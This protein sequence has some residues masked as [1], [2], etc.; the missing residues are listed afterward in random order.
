M[1]GIFISKVRYMISYIKLQKLNKTSYN[2]WCYIMATLLVE[3][4]LWDI[5]NGT[6]TQPTG[7]ANSKA[8]CAF[9][10]KQQLAHTKIILNIDRSQLL[11]THYDNLKEIWESLQKVHQAN[12]FSTCLSLCHHFFYM[13]KHNDQPMVSWISGIKN[14]AFQLEAAGATTIDEDVILALIEGLPESYSTSLHLT[15]FQLTILPLTSL[16]PAH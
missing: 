15:A 16:S 1:L 14:T 8:I 6:E 3:K 7:S 13:C 2:D 12:G 5:V 10:K 11:H 4:D 9:A